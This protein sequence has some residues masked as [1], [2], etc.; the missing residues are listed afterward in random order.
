M[1]FRDIP[2]MNGNHK[3]YSTSV[4]F[5]FDSENIEKMR[6]HASG[7]GI[8]LNS[9]INQIVK[10]Y[11]EWHIF[12]SKVGFVSILKPVVKEIFTK[13]SKEQIIQI[14]AN[15]GK[16]EVRNALYFM[17]GRTDLDSFL[18]WFE[19]KMKNSSIQISHTFD[20]TSRIHTYVVKHDISENWSLYLK[21]IIEYIF[22]EVLER[23]V[24]V[25]ISNTTLT[26]KFGEEI[27]V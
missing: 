6:H 15:S 17:K 7:L 25:S 10:E 26:F 18:S 1:Y 24:E 3:T 20:R 27:I 5:R 13:M 21:Q 23:R 16:E 8:S 19:A 12:E 14:A 4:T 2:D 9:L 11:F 22:N